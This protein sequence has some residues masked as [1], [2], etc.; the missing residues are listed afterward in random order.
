MIGPDVGLKG[1]EEIRI[2]QIAFHIHHTG[3][4]HSDSDIMIEVPSDGVLFAGDIVTSRRIQSARPGEGDI[5]GQI[6][7]VEVALGT[8]SRWY[9]P[10]HGRVG[11]REI[12]EKQLLFLQQLLDAVHH[13]YD[14][15]LSDFEM[16][17]LVKKDLTAYSDW[18][19][20][21]ELG[22]VIGHVYL[23]VENKA[24]E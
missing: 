12:A 1:G 23:K 7:A 4:A 16:V 6:R 5:Y 10:G 14:R 8:N 21:D 15:G 22:R 18:Y 2:G 19:N 13:Y 11:G 9:V 24:F 17:E 3:T 20:F